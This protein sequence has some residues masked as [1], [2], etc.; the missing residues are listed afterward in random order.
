MRTGFPDDQ[1][2]QGAPRQDQ[3]LSSNPTVQSRSTQPSSSWI[4]QEAGRTEA[5]EYVGQRLN[6]AVSLPVRYTLV[7][8]DNSNEEPGAAIP[9][10]PRD[11]VRV[12]QRC[13][14]VPTPGVYHQVP[15]GRGTQHLILS[16]HRCYGE[17]AQR[18][19][20]L[21]GLPRAAPGLVND[22]YVMFFL[23]WINTVGLLRPC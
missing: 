21:F 15:S 18:G 6:E 20:H 4:S 1:F 16:E 11:H 8:W 3:T 14:T 23:T 9:A 2:Q 17:E 19:P 12:L 22:L 13:M 7:H 10:T 5:V